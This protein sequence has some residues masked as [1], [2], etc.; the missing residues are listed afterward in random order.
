M[1][2]RLGYWLHRHYGFTF[3]LMG[4][5]AFSFGAIS[6]NLAFLLRANIELILENGIMVLGEGALRQLLELLGFGYASLVFYILFKT[7]ENVL[8]A[9]LS[10]NVAEAVKDDEPA[11]S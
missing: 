10:R 4:L 2:I 8:V 1:R 9:R 11:R 3:V 5:A 6:L 7:C